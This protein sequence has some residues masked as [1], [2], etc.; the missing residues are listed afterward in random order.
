MSLPAR[1]PFGGPAPSGMELVAAV[2]TVLSRATDAARDNDRAS[3][4]VHKE[5]L[6]A[7][8]MVAD[9]DVI[10]GPVLAAEVQQ[11]FDMES[12]QYRDSLA[13]IDKR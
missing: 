13:R 9:N 7:L 4:E 8:L 5:L 2:K 1:R 6:L 10:A 12:R 11:F 3:Y